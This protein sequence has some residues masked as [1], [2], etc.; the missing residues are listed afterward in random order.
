MQIQPRSLKLWCFLYFMNEKFN[1]NAKVEKLTKKVGRG[2]RL[3]IIG[4]FQYG[5]VLA[6]VRRV[7]KILMS[8]RCVTSAMCTSLI[9]RSNCLIYISKFKLECI[10]YECICMENTDRQSCAQFDV[11]FDVLKTWV[12]DNVRERCRYRQVGHYLLWLAGKF[13]EIFIQIYLPCANFSYI[14]FSCRSVKRA[15]ADARW[16]IDRVLLSTRKYTTF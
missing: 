7:C 2:V 1:K 15:T 9:F 6:W 16:Y 12:F 5:A 11:N 4:P 14:T 3:I 13:H 8:D 10:F